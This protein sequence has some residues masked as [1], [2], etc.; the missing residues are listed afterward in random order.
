[1]R[2]PKYGTPYFRKHPLG[3]GIKDFW[4]R[5]FR[6]FPASGFSALRSEEFTFE[7]FAGG[8]SKCS[9]RRS[10]QDCRFLSEQVF[11]GL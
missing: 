2:T 9:F 5:G 6:A 8:Y 1:M 3:L 10:L 4:L 11:E 7:G